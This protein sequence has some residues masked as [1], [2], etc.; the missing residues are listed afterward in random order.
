MRDFWGSWPAEV[1]AFARLG[2]THEE[3]VLSLVTRIYEYGNPAEILTF[4]DPNLTHVG[5]GAA[6]H[7][8]R[9]MVLTKNGDTRHTGQRAIRHAIGA[10]IEKFMVL[11][12]NFYQQYLAHPSEVDDALETSA[13]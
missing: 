4:C 8:F 6:C 12:P 2:S 13:N 9:G 7:L 11:P 5:Q 1:E 3:L 10:G